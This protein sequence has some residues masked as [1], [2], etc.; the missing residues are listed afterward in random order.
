MNEV[1][2][3]VRSIAKQKKQVYFV[4]PVIEESEEEDLK[5]AETTFKEL[6]ENIFREFTIGLIHGRLDSK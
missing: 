6:K 1:Y 5:A 3:F 2:E 4:C